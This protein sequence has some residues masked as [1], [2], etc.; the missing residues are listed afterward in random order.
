MARVAARNAPEPGTGWTPAAVRLGT[1]CRKGCPKASLW[2]APCTGMLTCF[3][4]RESRS[5]AA[6]GA[7]RS[8]RSCGRGVSGCTM[9][10]AM[11]PPSG[12]ANGTGTLPPARSRTAGKEGPRTAREGLTRRPRCKTQRMVSA[13]CRPRDAIEASPMQKDR[14]PAAT[15]DWGIPASG[16]ERLALD[17][18]AG[19]PGCLCKAGWPVTGE[20]SRNVAAV[21]S[22]MPMQRTSRFSTQAR[23]AWI[24]SLVQ[25][26]GAACRIGC[27]LPQA[28]EAECSHGC[29]KQPGLPPRRGQLVGWPPDTACTPF[30]LVGR[31]QARPTNGF[32]P[33]E[34]TPG[35]PMRGQ[36]VP[37]G[38]NLPPYA[39]RLGGRDKV[40]TERPRKPVKTW[41]DQDRVRLFFSGKK[42]RENF[43]D[44]DLVGVFYNGCLYTP[45]LPER[46][47]LPKYAK[48]WRQKRVHFCVAGRGQY[49][50]WPLSPTQAERNFATTLGQTL[51]QSRFECCVR[52]P[53]SALFDLP[54]GRHLGF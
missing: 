33:K 43:L 32:S 8:A 31:D 5:R 16:G 36:L 40:T 41:T 15:T 11:R 38:L 49:N 46:Q 42:P 14:C 53:L 45:G 35:C 51:Q 6:A 52:I 18:R 24:A 48:P 27:P 29:R 4:V 50:P 3:T 30:G 26:A 7:I 21:L 34:P 37:G 44:Q 9:N 2:M 25:E 23:D 1:R 22:A 47:L 28:A 12:S 54:F 13:A 17:G 20:P 19:R 10:K 39:R